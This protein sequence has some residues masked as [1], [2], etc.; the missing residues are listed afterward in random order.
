MKKSTPK[1]NVKTS[2]LRAKEH[3]ERKKEYIINLEKRV[4]ELEKLNLEL[5]L[6]NNKLKE[7]V[8]T[9]EKPNQLNEISQLKKIEDF[10]FEEIPKMMEKDPEKVRF[11]MI[12]EEIDKISNFA[13]ERVNLIKNSFRTILDSID[14]PDSKTFYV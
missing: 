7:L 2:K 10:T 14:S 8:E 5:T 9:C 4:T 3:R 13:D 12:E 6:E 1:Q 11:T